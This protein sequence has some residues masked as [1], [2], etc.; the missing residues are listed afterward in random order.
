MKIPAAQVYFH[1]EDAYVSTMSD[2]RGLLVGEGPI[3]LIRDYRNH[4]EKLGNA[5]VDAMNRS[6]AGVLRSEV[7]NSLSEQH[8]RLANSNSW[9]KFATSSVCV[10][11]RTVEKQREATLWLPIRSGKY[12]EPVEGAV[13]YFSKDESPETIGKILIDLADHNG[14]AE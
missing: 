13:S 14:E 10:G 9:E 7:S 8:A 6:R 12:M 4:L 1:G 11:V 2:S 5:L 3:V